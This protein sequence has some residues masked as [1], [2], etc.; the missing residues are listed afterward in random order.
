MVTETL[1]AEAERGCTHMI[2]RALH[3]SEDTMKEHEAMGF[4]EG[5][6]MAATQLEG[7]A[8]SL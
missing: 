8:K 2:W 1:L 5:W 4:H 3:W 6:G 7:L